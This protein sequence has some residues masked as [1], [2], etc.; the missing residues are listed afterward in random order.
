MKTMRTMR[1]ISAFAI[2]LLFFAGLTNEA[3]AQKPSNDKVVTIEASMT[4]D[5]CKKSIENKL[6]K[7][8]GVKSV[9]ADSKTK[10]VV[11]TYDETKTNDAALVKSIEKMGYNAKVADPNEKKAGDAAKKSGGG[12]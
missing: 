7:E 10:L 9:V 1:T 11:V 3:K 5:G 2:T 6:A 4:C 12:C 8:K